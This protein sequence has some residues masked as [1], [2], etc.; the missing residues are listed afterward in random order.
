M[1]ASHFIAPLPRPC[2]LLSGRAEEVDGEGSLTS[3]SPQAG[4]GGNTRHMTT[5]KAGRRSLSFHR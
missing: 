3:S 1:K 4:T 5:L 2:R